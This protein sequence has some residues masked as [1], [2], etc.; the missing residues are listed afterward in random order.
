MI[1]IH[2]HHLCDTYQISCVSHTLTLSIMN[3][4]NR[5][6][7]QNETLPEWCNEVKQVI[8]KAKKIANHFTSSRPAIKFLIASQH[9]HNEI[10]TRI[11][12]FSVTRWAGIFFVL[13]SL[14]QVKEHA[15]RY[16]NLITC[17][18]KKR[19][20]KLSNCQWDII[21]DLQVVLKETVDVIYQLEG[22]DSCISTV[23]LRIITLIQSLETYERK[24]YLATKYGIEF[25][26]W[27]KEDIKQRW[28]TKFEENPVYLLSAL[29]D[30]IQFIYLPEIDIFRGKNLLKE[31]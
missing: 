13:E 23:Y 31:A 29:L 30:P 5:K 10:N 7:K 24:N 4:L 21:S 14:K 3:G 15:D 1:A 17:R 20:L 26:N 12:T 9:E 2:T 16:F 18:P 19:N 27:F 28:Y 6:K 22:D 25:W 11:I 8:R